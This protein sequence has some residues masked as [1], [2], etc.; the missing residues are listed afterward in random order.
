MTALVDAARESLATCKW[1]YECALEEGDLDHAADLAFCIEE[2]EKV[3]VRETIALAPKRVE[4]V[5]VDH[6]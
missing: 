6:R 1:A 3:L 4:A 5:N 2:I